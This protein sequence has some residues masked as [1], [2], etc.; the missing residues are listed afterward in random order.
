MARPPKGVS[1]FDR[2]YGGV[3]ED[4]ETGCWAVEELA[5]GTRYRIKHTYISEGKVA[6]VH[7]DTGGDVVLYDLEISPGRVRRISPRQMLKHE[8][9][10]CV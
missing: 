8:A 9:V 3:K 1:A 5:E 7:R 4:P 6:K 2:W 10:D